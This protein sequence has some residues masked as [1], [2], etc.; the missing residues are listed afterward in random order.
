MKEHLDK[1]F[2]YL[3][4]EKCVADN[5]L[6]AYRRDI[7]QFVTYLEQY[8]SIQSFDQLTNQHIKD[9]LKYARYQIGV[10][11]KSSSRKL[12]ALKTLANYLSRYHDIAPF[13]QG[14]SFPKLPKQLP[15]NITQDQ[16]QELL[17]TAAQ[18]G[19]A[20]GQRNTL[21]ICLLYAC[22]M[23]VSELV[24]LKI[25]QIHM[26]EQYI[27]VLG[28]GNKERL[29]PIAP[30]VLGLLQSYVQVTHEYLLGTHTVKRSKLPVARTSDY[31]FPVVYAGAISHITRQAFWRILK[32]IAHKSG[33][34][35]AVSPHVLRHSLATHMLKRGANLRVL[36]TLLG[37]EKINTVQV[38]THLDI[39]H[40][41]ELYNKY[42][43][44]A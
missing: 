10:N 28:K 17:K 8:T 2:N 31:L 33:L 32:E 20:L 26:S 39:T 16:V 34:I 5:T 25:S 14:V 27:K 24:A 9:F 41:Q 12:S 29:I 37:H 22:G 36:Q 4:T 38:Y 44:R 43:P 42:H 35:H 40:L 23:R 1:F 21:M 19:S 3:L 15:K 13:T 30:E 7:D 6:Q 18:D 11:P